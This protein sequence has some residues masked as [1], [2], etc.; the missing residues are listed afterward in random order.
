MELILSS[1]E[2]EFLLEILEEHHHE[3]LREIARTKHREFK[4]ILKTKE[5]L[6]E[7]IVKKVELQQPADVM[8]RSA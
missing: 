1:M 8:L 4:Q 6:L 7:S 3:L 5:K 2:R